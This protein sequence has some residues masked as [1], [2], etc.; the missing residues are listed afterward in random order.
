M[1]DTKRKETPDILGSL[2]GGDEQ[3][4]KKRPESQPAVKPVGHN[5]GTPEGKNTIM[6]AGQ[7]AI[8]LA[9][10]KK[11][12]VPPAPSPAKEQ[13][14]SGDKLKAT[15]YLS[16]EV[17]DQLEESWIRLRRMAPKEDRGQISKSLIVEMAI[18]MALEELES[19]G[20][21][22]LLAKKTRKE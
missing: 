14:T 17:L 2:L 5:T 3:E 16:T 22:S 8:R 7:Q 4:P 1:A 12:A 20:I 9:G 6:P 15:Y 19:K 18:Q 11:P 10:K 21:K 13:E